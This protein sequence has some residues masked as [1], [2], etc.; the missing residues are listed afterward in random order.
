MTAEKVIEVADRYIELFEMYG[1]EPKRAHPESWGIDEDGDVMATHLIW[2]CHEIKKFAE[3]NRMDKAFRWLGFVQGALWVAGEY[4][5]E[6][7]KGHNKP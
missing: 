5:I 1:T 6:D 2:M 4:T 7:F 3:E